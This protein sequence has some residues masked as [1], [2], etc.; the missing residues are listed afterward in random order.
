MARANNTRRIAVCLLAAGLALGCQRVSGLSEL[1][2]DRG[3]EA[4]PR[5]DGGGS[6]DAGEPCT[7]NSC[8][9]NMICNGVCMLPLADEDGDSVPLGSDCDSRSARSRSTA[10]STAA[11]ASRSA[12]TATTTRGS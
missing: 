4:D 10:S 8:P 5:Q 9:D 6:A 2:I 3:V 12:A 11:M 7:E 1:K